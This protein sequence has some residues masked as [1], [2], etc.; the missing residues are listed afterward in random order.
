[1][2][3]INKIKKKKI[4]ISSSVLKLRYLVCVR[5][6]HLV[7]DTKDWIV[8]FFVCLFCSVCLSFSR[9]HGDKFVN[10]AFQPPTSERFLDEMQLSAD[11]WSFTASKCSPPFF[12][13][14]VGLSKC[15]V[16]V[17]LFSLCVS[18]GGNRCSFPV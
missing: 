1:M 12:A 6:R 17:F 16:V 15:P 18:N 11:R 9:P 10:S 13:E 8:F 5:C 7:C 4:T 14:C 2:L 3:A